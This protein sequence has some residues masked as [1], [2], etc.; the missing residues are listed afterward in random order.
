ML[1]AGADIRILAGNHRGEP[2]KGPLAGCV[3]PIQNLRNYVSHVEATAING[4]LWSKLEPS[5][6]WAPDVVLVISDV[7]GF[8]GLIE[9][10]TEQVWQSKPLFHYC[11]IE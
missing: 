3:W 8:L 10:G 7:S 6:F 11:P 9:V 2:I 1:A 5:D 4:G